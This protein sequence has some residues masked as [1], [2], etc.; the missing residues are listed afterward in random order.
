MSESRQTMLCAYL[1]AAVLIGLL[2]NAVAG[3]WWADPF[4]ALVIGLSIALGGGD[5]SR[6]ASRSSQRLPPAPLWPPR[7][8]RSTPTSS[9]PTQRQHR[10]E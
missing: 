6:P 10:G 8:L 7:S 9:L 5:C 1:S 2:A 3:W 4:V